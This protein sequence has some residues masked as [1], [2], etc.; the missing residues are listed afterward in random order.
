MIKHAVIS[1]LF[2]TSSILGI[3][4]TVSAENLV[5]A[6]V[7]NTRGLV[8]QVDLDSRSEYQTDSGWRHIKFWLSTRG[9]P[10]KHSAIASC[11]PYDIQSPY[12]EW[13]WLPS[14]GGYPAG[15]V[16]GDIAR[17]VCNN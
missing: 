3:A 8:Y 6:A 13:N 2:V 1:S 14:G 12:Y 4:R 5:I 11:A 10:K 15:T 9:D 16:V 17:V 7:D